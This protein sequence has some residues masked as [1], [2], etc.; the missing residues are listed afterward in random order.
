[1]L[2]AIELALLLVVTRAPNTQ[3]LMWAVYDGLDRKLPTS[4]PAS[5]IRWQPTGQW[6]ALMAFAA[7]WALLGLSGVSEFLYFQF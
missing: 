1:L 6:A 3:Q 2:I 7:T 4:P 5:R